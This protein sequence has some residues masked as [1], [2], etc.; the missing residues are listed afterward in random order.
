MY[1]EI[2][3]GNFTFRSYSILYTLAFLV[4]I[5]I[6]WIEMKRR[7]EK[8][9]IF[10]LISLAL[11]L[12]GFVG[13]KIFYILLNVSCKDFLKIPISTILGQGRIYH[14]G[15]FLSILV[16]FLIVKLTRRNFWTI[17]DSTA[18]ALAI[19]ISIGR[20]G[21]FLNGCCLGSPT[22][23][24]W[25]VKFYGI[26]SSLNLKR[27]PAQLYESIIMFFIFLFLW[28]I[29]KKNYPEGYIFSRY[30]LVWSC[31]RFI[32]EFLRITKPS[33]FFSLSIAQVICLAIAFFAIY[34]LVRLVKTGST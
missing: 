30:L 16:G 9:K 29:I 27:H 31:E 18:P 23:L 26:D 10:M 12:S 6:F 8:F 33:P 25:G 11:L 15:F 34:N 21:C 32:L 19:S 2:D 5:C 13:A 7:R 14:G 28:R 4:S 24:P 20:I 3:I 22:N 1:P 17:A